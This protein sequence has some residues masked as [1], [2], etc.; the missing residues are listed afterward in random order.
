VDK[1]REK[2]KLRNLLNKI[3]LENCVDTDKYRA[4]VENVRRHL[5]E[6]TKQ[7]IKSKKLDK[8]FVLVKL[9]EVSEHFEMSELCCSKLFHY[10]ED[11]KTR[12][13]VLTSLLEETQSKFEQ[14]MVDL[15]T[16]K[17]AYNS[18]ILEH[19]QNVF[20]YKQAEMANQQL[21]EKLK[22]VDEH[23]RVLESDLEDVRVQLLGRDQQTKETDACNCEQLRE[24]LDK[25]SSRIAELESFVAANDRT[26]EELDKCKQTVL[27]LT[28]ENEK[29]LNDLDELNKYRAQ[30]DEYENQLT[31]YKK[32]C[33]RLERELFEKDTIEKLYKEQCAKLEEQMVEKN[34]LNNSLKLTTDEL[35][36]AR[37]QIN[38]L[39]CK[40]GE[41]NGLVREKESR[42]LELRDDK[43]SGTLKLQ[44]LKE[45]TE[46]E[47]AE[48]CRTV[49]ELGGLLKLSEDKARKFEH[50]IDVLKSL[51]YTCEEEKRDFRA[52]V[53][54]QVIE[55]ETLKKS[56][57]TS[58]A[59][60]PKW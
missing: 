53:E 12:C 18:V 15:H 59:Q 10:L 44:E 9:K 31:V 55:Y 41:L 16:T 29:L 47:I 48:K 45:K 38:G 8:S 58:V 14:V 30:L 23:C 27:K 50:E 34:T 19:E 54:K 33:E 3:N 17:L 13:D 7:L 42:L 4:Y 21:N 32:N 60:P 57:R 46:K 51:L 49:D 40:V 22:I 43:E 1:L 36:A 20:K 39:E 2:T 5:R 56:Q 28:H 52:K 26:L 35:R 25:A 11:S 24:S 37:E 6:L